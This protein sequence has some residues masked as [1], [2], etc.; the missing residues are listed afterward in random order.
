M[1]IILI[2]P[3]AAGKGTQSELICDK[4][5]VKHIST[6]DLIRN[7][8][9]S[10]TEKSSELKSII[11]QGK[12]VSDEFVLDLIKEE[13]K[14]GKSY[15]FDGFPRTLNQARLFDELLN[16]LNKKVDYVIYL[17]ITK[18]VASK[19]ILGRVSCSNCGK[20]YN[21]QIEELMPKQNGICDTCNSNLSKRND[22]NEETFNT[23]FD[24]YI[25]NTKPL[26]D[27]YKDKLFIVDSSLNKYEIFKQI[28]NIIGAYDKN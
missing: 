13:I 17:D 12:L 9:N 4:Y 25:E 21:D 26:L 27:Y 11:D 7:V 20:V 24:T 6:G 15:I 2:A 1:N 22:D 23:R 16:N 3:P 19:R 28:E 8:I 10:N 5:D 18:E 14:D